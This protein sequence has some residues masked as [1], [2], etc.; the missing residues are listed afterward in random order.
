MTGD[1]RANQSWNWS[2]GTA[3]GQHEFVASTFLAPSRTRQSIC[4]RFRDLA[5]N[6]R[7][8][9]ATGKTAT[10]QELQRGLKK[11]VAKCW[12]LLPR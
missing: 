8:T 7:R 1:D 11:A 10:L 4:S 2:V 12:R 6:I 9:A 3:G 5:V